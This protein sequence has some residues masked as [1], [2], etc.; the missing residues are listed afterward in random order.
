VSQLS[1]NKVEDVMDKKASNAFLDSDYFYSQ[2][3]T[4]ISDTLTFEQQKAIKSVLKRAIRI[5]SKKLCSIEFT[6]WFIRRFYIV[7]YLGIDKRNILRF[8]N[9]RSLSSFS[10]YIMHWT[11]SIM[12]WGATLFVM[13]AVVYYA[14]S[15]LD[16]N[17]LPDKHLEDVIQDFLE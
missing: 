16:I 3:P 8:V 2:I 7:L 9:A 17:L 14:K 4:N 12:L 1:K 15:T 11:I 10:K 13:A 6:F 5:P